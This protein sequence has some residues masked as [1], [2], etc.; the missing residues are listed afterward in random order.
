MATRQDSETA[1]LNRIKRA[2]GQIDGVIRMIE[3]GRECSEIVLQLAAATKA[4]E[5]VGFLMIASELSD[6]LAKG[7]GAAKSQAELEKLFLSLA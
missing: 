3:D 2:R 6:C 7:K 1:V 5:R 4:L